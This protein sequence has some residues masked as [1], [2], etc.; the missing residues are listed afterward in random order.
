MDLRCYI[1]GQWLKPANSKS[2][3]LINPA[4][5]KE[6]ASLSLA[7]SREVELAVKAARQALAVYAQST[8]EERLEL[9]QNIAQAL[10]ARQQ[11]LAEAITQEM[12][13]PAWFSKN[14][15]AAL[16][17]KHV[18]ATIE[19]LKNYEFDTIMGGSLVRRTPVGVCGMITPWNWPA[20]Q[21][22][23]KVAPA[24]ACGCTMV[25]KPS[26]YTPLS[27]SILARAL[28]QA[29]TPQG[30]FN[31]V[32]GD[33]AT[34]GFALASHPDIDCISITG[35]TRSGVEVARSAAP[36]VK[37]VLQE[38][39]GKSPNIVLPDANLELAVSKGVKGL[40]ANAG[41]SC[42]APSRLLLPKESIAQAKKLMLAMAGQVQPGPP[43]N[44]AY[45]GPLANANQW[46]RVQE[47]IA[48]G[49]QEGAQ[50][51]LGGLGKPAGLETGYYAKPTIFV[52]TRPNMKIV[53]EEIFGPVLVVQEYGSVEEA[54]N[55]ANDSEYGLAAYVQGGDLE[56]MRAV[57]NRLLAGQ[58]YLNSAGM[59]VDLAVPFGGYKKS[60]NGREWGGLAF[61]DYLELKSLLGYFP[62]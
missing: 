14:A 26:E 7:G 52:N 48:W 39:G 9:L 29:G 6:F 8:R 62:T 37:R 13:A 59:E 3:A 60:G 5:E 12:G 31:M 41:Q 53:R 50:A 30:V 49:L 56:Q 24:L 1:D 20:G 38:L 40:M 10:R 55:L 54:I 46:A 58:V 18:E 61:S 51:I 17:F 34:V 35:S 33:G 47:Y 15:Q 4:T 25:L 36:T 23:A 45:M 11:E 32:F 44:N 19:A 27:A 28:H 21:I 22:M 43:A 42:S 16:P 2:F 57:A